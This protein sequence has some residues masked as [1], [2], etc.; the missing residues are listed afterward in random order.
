LLSGL[1]YCGCCGAKFNVATRDFMR[2]S[3]RT[4]SGT[5]LESRLIRMTEVEERVLT[6]LERHLLTPEMVDAA[7]EAYE[8]EMKQARG[9]VDGVRER[10][11]SEL[12]SV[13]AKLERV[14]RL[15][16]DGHAD[17]AVAGPRLNELSAKKRQLV[18]DLAVSPASEPIVMVSDGGAGY[19]AMVGDL[20]VQ[21]CD[22]RQTA[23]EAV[24]LVR[25]LIRRITVS[26]QSQGERQAIEI[27]AGFSPAQMSNDRYCTGGC[28]GWI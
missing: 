12:A 8:L 4:N 11:R 2:C 25:R 17:P 28:G 5:C 24:S 26:P 18:A 19:R 14:L 10:L 9:A 22:E 1:I 20:R 3:A 16:E 13:E 27:E 7:V 6:S 15:V 23:G 21:L